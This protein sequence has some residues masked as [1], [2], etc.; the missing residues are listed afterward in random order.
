[1]K[2]ESSTT[3]NSASNPCDAEPIFQAI[4]PPKKNRGAEGKRPPLSV[5]YSRLHSRAN[6]DE[7]RLV[8]RR[9]QHAGVTVLWDGQQAHAVAPE[10]VVAF[11]NGWK[12]KRPS[13]GHLQARPKVRI[14]DG[15]FNDLWAQ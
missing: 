7:R 10:E 4:V 1:M 13:Q 3:W 11:S 6:V 8:V 5:E 9:P 14:V 12:P 2:I 15:P